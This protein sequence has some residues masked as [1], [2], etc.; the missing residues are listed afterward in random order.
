MARRH[1]H[2]ESAFEDFLRSEGVPYVAVDEARQ[3]IFAGAKV[4]SFDFLVY[5]TNQTTWLA[6]IKGRR[7]PYEGIGARRYWENWVTAED[8]ESLGCWEQ[9]FGPPFVAAF[10]FAYWLEGPERVWPQTPVHSY[11]GRFYGFVA[12]RLCDYRRY[13]RRRSTRWDTFAMPR[14]LF[15]RIARP[16]HTWWRPDRRGGLYSTPERPIMIPGEVEACPLQT[17]SV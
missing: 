9:A 8:L 15:R 10:V 17:R 16:V 13:C 6:D 12:V 5:G 1:I 2:Y 14:G 7:F 3:A 11:R 4:K